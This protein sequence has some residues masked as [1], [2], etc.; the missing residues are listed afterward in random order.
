MFGTEAA[1]R[2][3]R[4]ASFVQTAQ[5]RR[6]PHQ[7]LIAQMPPKAKNAIAPMTSHMMMLF[8]VHLRFVH[9]ETHFP[10]RRTLCTFPFPASVGD[11]TEIKFRPNRRHATAIEVPLPLS[12]SQ[13]NNERDHRDRQSSPTHPQIRLTISRRVPYITKVTGL[14]PSL[15]AKT[16]PPHPDDSGCPLSVRIVPKFSAVVGHQRFCRFV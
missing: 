7:R 4:A 3:R 5:S 14:L 13:C 2:F 11:T 6:P 1:R 8:I 16:I 9:R 15:K 10:R 12:S